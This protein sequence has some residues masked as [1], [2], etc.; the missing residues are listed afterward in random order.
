MDRISRDQQQPTPTTKMNHK[1]NDGMGIKQT[2]EDIQTLLTGQDKTREDN[3]GKAKTEIN[4]RG[5]HT[6]IR[7]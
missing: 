6:N 1:K 4:R 7:H 3:P 5:L 2:K